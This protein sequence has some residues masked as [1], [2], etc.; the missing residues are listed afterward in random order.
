MGTGED[1]VEERSAIFREE[2]GS[3]EHDMRHSKEC[4]ANLRFNYIE[5]LHKEIFLR[6]LG[7]EEVPV[8]RER[9]GE[10]KKRKEEIDGMDEEMEQ[11]SRSIY[12][13]RKSLGERKE[14][15]EEMRQKERNMAKRLGEVAKRRELLERVRGLRREE[16]GNVEK[17][18][19]V[20]VDV[21]NLR[22]RVQEK[23][24][25]NAERKRRVADV[26]AKRTLLEKKVRAIEERR[27]AESLY[28]YH[29]HRQFNDVATRLLGLSVEGVERNE[30]RREG[31]F[32]SSGE[33]SN[34]VHSSEITVSVK[35]VLGKKAVPLQ[36]VF[37]DG[38]LSGVSFVGES[39][40][41][42]KTDSL[43][44]YCILVSSVKYMLFEMVFLGKEQ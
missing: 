39:P 28:L 42:G 17:I 33:G 19:R 6:A 37:T 16:E 40:L 29:W 25:E 30:Y 21:D 15:L 5:L 20:V 8:Q 36:I 27:S 35:M 3:I 38:R 10:L 1:S 31:V 41:K 43:L 34:E 12:E 23:E 13:E 2:Y 11:L 9:K 7:G 32:S 44:S 26:R 14:H 24:K 18:S 4:L 22:A